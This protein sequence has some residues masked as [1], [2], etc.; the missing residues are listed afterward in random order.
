MEKVVGI[1]AWFFMWLEGWVK[2]QGEGDV[3]ASR[4]WAVEDCIRKRESGRVWLLMYLSKSLRLHSRNGN[5]SRSSFGVALKPSPWPMPC[6]DEREI[7]PRGSL[8]VEQLKSVDFKSLGLSQ[9][10]QNRK[11][12]S[13]PTSQF[14][15]KAPT[16]SLTDSLCY[17]PM[18]P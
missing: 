10:L 16:S 18:Q 8:Q 12:S 3:L 17:I 11:I 2:Q 5:S 14:M 1:H 4:S 7:V 13:Q 6:C 9:L 15:D